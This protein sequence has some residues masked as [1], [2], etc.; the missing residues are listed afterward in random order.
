MKQPHVKFIGEIGDQ[1]KADFLGHAV[2]CL[3][4]IDWPEPFGLNM[5]ESMACGTPIIAFR[6]GS[7]PE[8]IDDGVSGIIVDSVEEAVQTIDRARSMS[9]WAC[10]KTFER[11][12]TA[13]RMAND[14]LKLYRRQL[15][16]DIS[17]GVRGVKSPEP[18]SETEP[19]ESSYVENAA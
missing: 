18:V 7:V 17:L 14:Y 6:H 8:I 15:E 10:R 12:F 9:R 3:A 2:A 1:E 4:P 5:I 19:A 11:R 16:D 13:R